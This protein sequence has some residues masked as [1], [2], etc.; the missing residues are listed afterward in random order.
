MSVLPSQSSF[1]SVGLSLV[2][3][4]RLAV[5]IWPFIPYFKLKVCD[6][7]QNTVKYG[8]CL[9]KQ[10]PVCILNVGGYFFFEF[11]RF[12]TYSI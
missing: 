2:F 11:P 5:I 6:T 9:V 3:G 4:A 7:S 8:Y 10:R 12:L 1:C